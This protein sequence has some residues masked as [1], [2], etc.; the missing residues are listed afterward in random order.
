MKKLTFMAVMAIAALAMT[1]CGN[2]RPP[3]A[4]LKNNIDS[5]SYAQGVQVGTQ[6][7]QYQVLSQLKVDSTEIGEFMKGV[8]EAFNASDDKKT[9]AYFA[10]VQIGSQLTTFVERAESEYFANDS[11]KKLSRD[12]YLA[13][14]FDMIM[15]KE[16]KMTPE[17]ADSVV[18]VIEKQLQ[19]E[20]YSETKKAGEEFI[21]KKASEE[22]VKK[23]ESGLL[24]KVITEGNGPVAVEGDKAKVTYEGSFT[25][26]KV[27]D[28][29]ERHG[30]E[31]VEFPVGGGTVPG[32]DEALRMMPAGSEWEIYLPYNLGYGENGYG[33]MIPPYSAL[34]FKL[35]VLEVV[36]QK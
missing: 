16:G 2:N 6:F 12:N 10:G 28:S 9:A 26:G 34:T 29:T 23:T 33:Q 5:L 19:E 13:A 24:Y 30:G 11:T 31:P 21:A 25:D 4:D 18:R 1:S 15:G 8:K 14:F 32:F 36:K 20:R 35:K 22:G 17:V 7:N 3:K 27:F